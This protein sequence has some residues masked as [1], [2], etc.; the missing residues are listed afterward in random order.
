NHKEL[1]RELGAASTVLLKNSGVL[2]LDRKKLDKI[3]IVG[4]DA[5][6][7]PSGLN[8]VDHGCSNGTL[9]QGW[10]SGTAYYPYLVDPLTGLS[11]ALG[12]KVKI[13]T[14]LDD[15]DLEKAAK[16][17]KDADYAIVF[18]NSDSGEEY[19][20]VD[21]NAG[22][23]NNLS[24]WHNGDNL[25]KAVADANK[26]TI[27]VIHAV[28]AVLMPWINHPNIKAVVWPGLQGQESGNALADVMLGKVNPSARLPYT[29]AKEASDYNA[30]PD[31]NYHIPYSE[32][33]L[34]GYKWFD[35]AN[36]EPLFPF[37][38]GLSYTTFKYSNLKVKASN[39]GKKSATVKA[40]ISIQ[41]SGKVDGAEVVQA[42]L[43]FPKSAGEPPKLL[44]GF[45]K[46]YLKKG[47]K[48]TVNFE[49]SK[50]ELSIW[51]V[52][53]NSWVIPSGKF[54][55]HVGASSRDIRQSASFT[56]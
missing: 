11:D 33:L 15:W 5:G 36:I 34:M 3:A 28:G 45:E 14:S 17:A 23:R 42:Y 35:H 25:I 26:N 56:L 4:S 21:G 10:G 19:I 8:C 49:L 13:A 29:I 18:S 31:P 37:G 30:K 38:H 46:V 20:T 53:S 43:S 54:T 52:K 50:T 1:V 44:R 16:T 12:K 24:L 22:D 47:K 55:L 32:K 48:E 39:S 9:A 6:R 7:D 51:D 40:S 27:V 2:P 41:N